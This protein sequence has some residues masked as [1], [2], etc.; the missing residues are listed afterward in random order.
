MLGL[1]RFCRRL[2]KAVLRLDGWLHQK[3]QFGEGV[4]VGVCHVVPRH[5]YY[6]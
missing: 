2:V 3:T 1:V 6:T 5:T 4:T